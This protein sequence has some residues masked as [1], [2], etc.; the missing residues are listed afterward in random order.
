MAAPQVSP[1]SHWRWPPPPGGAEDAGADREP[2]V[3][4]P[5]HVPLTHR[6]TPS[7]PM[8]MPR[9]AI[10]GTCVALERASGA[11]IAVED[12]ELG[13]VSPLAPAF[14][15]INAP[16]R[17]ARRCRVL[18]ASSPRIT[19]GLAALRVAAAHASGHA[20]FLRVT[21]HGTPTG[22]EPPVL[23]PLQA[24]ADSFDNQRPD[25]RLGGTVVQT[26]RPGAQGWY[27]FVRPDQPLLRDRGHQRGDLF[28]HP[29]DAELGW[30]PAVG[31][32]VRSCWACTTGGR[33]PSRS[34]RTGPRPTPESEDVRA[35]AVRGLR[36]RAAP[37]LSM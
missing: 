11:H 31:D 33:R 30:R 34:A 12:N 27:G 10:E 6:A 37:G 13:Q 22:R 26:R 18:R 5:E 15:R 35:G 7:A 17:R 8:P 16:W 23:S 1:D 21:P 20:A 32:R 24:P 28:L 14:G 9:I 3:P 2:L 36:Q 19:G 4:F 25:G 29:S